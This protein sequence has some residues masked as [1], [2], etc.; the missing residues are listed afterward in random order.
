MLTYLVGDVLLDL[1]NMIVIKINCIHKTR[2]STTLKYHW[3]EVVTF[4]ILDSEDHT[5]EEVD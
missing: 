4:K 3:F 1:N 2:L 5:Y